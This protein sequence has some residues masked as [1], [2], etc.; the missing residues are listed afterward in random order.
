[1]GHFRLG[2]LGRLLIDAIGELLVILPLALLTW[3]CVRRVLPEGLQPSQAAAVH[4]HALRPNLA[5][6]SRI[7]CPAPG[8]ANGAAD[9]KCYVRPGRMAVFR[10]GAD[11][12]PQVRWNFAFR[13][14]GQRGPGW[15]VFAINDGG[16]AKAYRLVSFLGHGAVKGSNVALAQHFPAF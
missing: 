10:A 14:V 5:N 16:A 1:L 13:R 7:G 12:R 8:G 15:K 3:R 4:L 9:R 2:H 11:E 6:P